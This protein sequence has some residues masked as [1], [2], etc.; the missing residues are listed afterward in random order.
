VLQTLETG[1]PGGPSAQCVCLNTLNSRVYLGN[2]A[3][4]VVA[5]I[6][7]ISDTIV[8]RV[9]AG[10]YPTALCYSPAYNYVYAATTSS[11]VGVIDCGPNTLIARVA[12]GWS[13]A[14]LCYV[15][16][17]A[18]VYAAIPDNDLVSVIAGET[19]GV[20]ADI[21]VGSAPSAL[22]WN[23]KE[24]KV[25]CADFDD[26]D[27]AVIDASADTVITYLTVGDE[28]IALSYDLLNDYVYC[29]CRASNNV[30]VIDAHRDSVVGVVEVGAE[31]F[32]MAWNPIELRTY[33]LNYGSSSVSVLRDSLHVG[34]AEGGVGVLAERRVTPTVVRGVLP[35]APATSHKPQA[36][37]LL[38]ISGRKV[39]DLHP[40]GNDIRHLAPGVYFIRE[41]QAR[42]VRKVV[43]T[44]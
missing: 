39:L 5:V 29:A 6:D 23:S 43:I 19:P 24:N 26:G 36:A 21:D 35:L 34:V 16:V 28:P 12:V 10:G 3:D 4:T 38:D 41:A 31:P 37:S 42:A 15:P 14:A 9:P 22:C 44:K 33:V 30:Y 17:G 2:R 25:Y 40:G 27:V 32:A 20:V 13:P 7:P 8:A 18:K 11:T 1:A